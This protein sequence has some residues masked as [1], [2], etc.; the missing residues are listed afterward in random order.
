V[1]DFTPHMPLFF[2]VLDVLFFKFRLHSFP[3]RFRNPDVG[4]PL[5]IRLG[6]SDGSVFGQVFC[7]REYSCFDALAAPGLII[8]CG[9]NVGYSSVYFLN[10]FPGAFVIAL[11]PFPENFRVLQKNLAPYAGRCLALQQAVWSRPGRLRFRS[12]YSAKEAWM[13]E[14]REAQGEEPGEV[15]AVALG[16]VLEKSGFARIAILKV[17]VEGAEREIFSHGVESWLPRTDNIAIELHG[18]E[19]EKIFEAAVAGQQ[20]SRSRSGELTVCQRL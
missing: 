15:E 13:V 3:V 14:V 11:E 19:A 17:D 12:H 4:T 7:D 10:R 6:T 20:F 9:A 5:W 16:Q 2:A 1:R 8:D 18:A